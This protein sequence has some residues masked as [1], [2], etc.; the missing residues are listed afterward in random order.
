VAVVLAAALL[1]VGLA[2]LTGLAFADVQSS[3]Y[4]IGTP[5]PPVDGVMATP[6]P[7]APDSLTNFEV[8][9][10]AATSLAGGAG[11]FV[12]ITPS[13]PLGSTPGN[14]ELLD[15]I[16]C[17]QAGPDGGALSGTGL[18]VVLNNSC[19]ISA[20]STVEVDFTADAPVMSGTFTFAVTTSA[21]GTLARSNVVHVVGPT[22]SADSYMPG[23]STTYT[24][25]DVPIG[26][27]SA[28]ATA[29]TL[30][31]DATTGAGTITFLNSGAGGAGYAVTYTPPGGT[32]TSD[33]VNTAS[34]SGAMVT[35]TLATP[36]ANGD[37]LEVTA[38]GQNPAASAGPQA[39]RVVVT[40][41]NGTAESSNAI[42][43]GSSVTGVSVTPSLPVATAANTYTIAF[44][45]SSAVPASGDIFLAEPNGPTDFATVTGLEVIDNT[46]DVH[47][48]A[49]GV[50]LSSQGTATIPL[51]DAIAAGDSIS[52]V[53]AGVT[54]PAAAGTITDFTVATTDDPAAATA[55][56]YTI[57]ANAGPGVVV[58]VDPSATDAIA[59]YT[60]SNIHASATLTGGSSTIQLQ[61]P[62]GTAFPNDPSE[63]SITDATTPSGSGT[64]VAAVT[65]DSGN[66][67]T[68][69]V[70]N[71]INSGD[72]LTITIH[73]VVNPSLSSSTDSIKLVG[74]VTGP[75]PFAATTTTTTTMMKRPPPPPPRPTV[76]DLTTKARLRRKQVGVKLRCAAA[77]CRGDVKLANGKTVLASRRYSIRAGKTGT[78]T[79][80]LDRK[81]LRLLSHARHHTLRLAVTIT[82]AGGRTVKAKLRLTG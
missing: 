55:P 57:A 53:V 38:K 75:T 74:S 11:A 82:V 65:V 46:Q 49:S 2:V 50:V 10:T 18:T 31:A 69:T 3:Y 4:T 62:T 32:A 24:V 34:A 17:I 76:K 44:R 5:G 60:L 29:L 70:P 80:R 61:A 52:I 6:S 22:L 9:F 20:G 37:T 73:D 56:P 64:V 67:V 12:A 23:A 78:V 7:V 26:G 81:D 16:S 43:F 59:T 1:G 68:F 40:P 47:Y 79:V 25:S 35:L 71:R 45:A 72:V 15:G 54:N 14:V 28:S 30:T 39:N 21:N 27:I 33:S 41:G 42:A 8:T 48:V 58:T 13:T 36:L 19:S 66:V 77:T 63:Y 51:A